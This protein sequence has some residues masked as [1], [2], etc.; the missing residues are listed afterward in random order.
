[1]VTASSYQFGRVG[2]LDSALSPGFSELLKLLFRIHP[3][4][5]V[6]PCE[7]LGSLGPSQA[8]AEPDLRVAFG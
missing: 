8:P 5:T 4:Q 2:S 3:S 1:M 6:T 7:C